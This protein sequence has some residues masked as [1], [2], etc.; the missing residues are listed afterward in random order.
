MDYNPSEPEIWTTTPARGGALPGFRR[1]RQL[2]VLRVVSASAHIC[3][4]LG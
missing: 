2:R 3:S 1:S 4:A